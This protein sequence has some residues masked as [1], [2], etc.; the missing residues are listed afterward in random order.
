MP[1]PLD[2]PCIDICKLDPVTKL[3]LGC[4]RTLDEI[5]RWSQMSR[6]ERQL[7]LAKL[8]VRKPGW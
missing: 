3:C 4:W 2:S 1:K 5:A 8:P 6:A 7:V